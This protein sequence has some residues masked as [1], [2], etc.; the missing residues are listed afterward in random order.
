MDQE[1]SDLVK[2]SLNTSEV[3]FKLGYTTKGNSWG[4]SQVK[5]RMKDNLK[6]KAN[7]IINSIIEFRANIIE[8]KL[9]DSQFFLDFQDNLNLLSLDPN[10]TDS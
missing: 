5:Q 4:Y 8:N 9:Y 1:F 10:R 6:Q 7:E 3:L 2:S